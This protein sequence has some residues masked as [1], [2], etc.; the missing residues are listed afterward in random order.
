M[1]YLEELNAK[2]VL[3]QEVCSKEKKLK[4]TIESLRNQRS[5]L[6]DVQRQSKLKLQK[7]ADVNALKSMSLQN[8]LSYLSGN[9][10][11][12]LEKEQQE[13]LLA[14]P[15]KAEREKLLN[16]ILLIVA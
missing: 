16:M 9:R 3:A 5:Q 15:L 2:I 12:Q 8:F 13:S 6:L 4:S 14:K 7:E 1:S 11:E 10:A